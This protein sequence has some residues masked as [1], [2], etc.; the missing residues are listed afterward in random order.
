MFAVVP[1][2]GSAEA[3]SVSG[4][5]GSLLDELAREGAR[6]MLAAALEAKWSAPQILRGSGLGQA[7]AAVAVC[8]CWSSR[9]SRSSR[10]S[11]VNFQSKGVAVAL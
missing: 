2:G 11:A 7:A 1:A 5:A 9:A 4:S 6:R 3:A 8:S 10:S